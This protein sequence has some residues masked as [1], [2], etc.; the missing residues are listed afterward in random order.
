MAK[1]GNSKSRLTV[2]R[3]YIWAILSLW[4]VFVVLVLLWSLSRETFATEEVARIHARSAF[5]KD[6]VYRRWATSHGGV[7]VPVTNQTPSNPYLSNVEERDITTPSGRALTL[8]NH[9]YMTR[10]VHEMGAVQYGQRGHITSLNP[11]RPAKDALRESEEKWRFLLKSSPDAILNLD[12]DGTILFIN[13]TVPGYTVEDTVG[14]TVYDFIPPEEHE[15]TR[16]AI[17]E[18][19]QA[20]EAVSF[21]T[22]VIGPDGNLLWY[23][24]RLGPVKERDKV[25]GVAQISTD[26]TERKKVEEARRVSEKKF[27]DIAERSFD[28]IFTTDTNGNLTYVSPA[29][30]N[31][32]C[33]K[34]EE[35][36]GTHFKNYLV[37]SKIPRVS[38]R[39]A[40]NMRRRKKNFSA[41][42]IAM[43]AI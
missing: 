42:I 22:S 41:S 37:K 19:F 36:A 4:T 6:L 7:Y 20:G 12:R 10:Q 31:I 26:I 13:N 5:E 1:L 3:N 30:E 35:M 17:E 27:R 38:Q 2:L 24:T 16:K 14:K 21:E 40:E 39:F 15:K 23:S 11:I 32:F 18:V 9:A 25:V 34:P 33:Y 43:K 8:I 29:S 28:K